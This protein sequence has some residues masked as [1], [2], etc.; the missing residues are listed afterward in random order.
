V[1]YSTWAACE[2]A[3]EALHDTATM[4]GSEHPLV[5]KFADAKKNDAGLMPKRVR[6]SLGVGSSII[7]CLHVVGARQACLVSGS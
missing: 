4:P 1:Q 5:V 7:P 2:A 3:I 6:R